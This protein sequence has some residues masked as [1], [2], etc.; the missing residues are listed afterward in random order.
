MDLIFLDT[1][2]R[3]WPGFAQPANLK[4]PGKKEA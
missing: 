1:D 4:P 3:P 2:N